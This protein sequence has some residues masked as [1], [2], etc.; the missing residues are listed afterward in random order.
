MIV[1]T[2]VFGLLWTGLANYCLIAQTIAPE[3]LVQ[4]S[5]EYAI[6]VLPE[7]QKAIFNGGEYVPSSI[8]AGGHPYFPEDTFQPAT[9]TFDGILYKDID[10]LYD[11]SRDLVVI[12]DNSRNHICPPQQKITT[13][14]LADHHFRFIARL[15]GLTSGFYDVLVDDTISLYARRSK[16]IKGF[17][18]KKTTRY[19]VVQDGHAKRI[20]R[21][22][23]L[24]KIDPSKEKSVRNYIRQNRLSFRS[25][26]EASFISVIRYYSSLKV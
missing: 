22:K 18:W 12:E 24:F 13:F 16:T 11:A 4:E 8:V 6:E 23:D 21:R 3:T 17:Q 25:N 19:Y 1:R 10:L 14:T 9:I 5:L 2:C 15:E 7:D 26:R 20:E